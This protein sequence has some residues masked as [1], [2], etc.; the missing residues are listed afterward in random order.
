MI[1]KDIGVDDRIA[2]RKNLKQAFDFPHFANILVR[3]C[4]HIMSAPGGDAGNED[5]C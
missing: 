3:G 2:S 5:N 4:F 1:G